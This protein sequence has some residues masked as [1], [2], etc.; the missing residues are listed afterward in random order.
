MGQAH[1]QPATRNGH[2]DVWPYHRCDRHPAI[3]SKR[4]ATG[5]WAIELD[6]DVT[7]YIEDPS[8]WMGMG[9][10]RREYSYSI[11]KSPAGAITCEV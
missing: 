5:R 10:E 8:I 1:L 9:K 11:S 6:D 4:Q 7:Q 2:T 3:Q